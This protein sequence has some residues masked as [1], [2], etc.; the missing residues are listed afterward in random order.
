[1]TAKQKATSLI[2]DYYLP[3]LPSAQHKAGLTGLLLLIES[4]RRREIAPR[5]EIV[6]GPSETRV[7]IRLSPESLKALFDEFFAAVTIIH[8]DKQGKEKSKVFPR[9]EFLE[10]LGMPTCWLTLWRDVIANVIRAGAPAQFKSYRDRIEGAEPPNTWDWQKT[11]KELQ[12]NGSTAL[13]ASDFLGA[14]GTNA[15]RIPFKNQSC[16]AFLLIFA[17]LVSLTYI[18]QTLKRT[19]KKGEA[20]GSYRFQRNAY[21][22]VTP[23]VAVL[24]DFIN[25]YPEMLAGLNPKTWGNDPYP[26]EARISVPEEGGLEFLSSRRI[27]GERTSDYLVADLVASVQ[28]THLKYGKGSPHLLHVGTV[29]AEPEMLRQYEPIHQHCQNLFFRELRI[30]NL[31]GGHPWFEGADALLSEHPAEF[32]IQIRDKTPAF[33]FFGADVRR[34]FRGILSDLQE[35]KG[36][37]P[38]P[39][40][41]QDQELASQIYRLLGQFVN[42]RTKEKTDMSW[43][44][45]KNKRGNIQ[46]YREAREKVCLDAFLAMRGR[47]G[48]DLVSYF[49]GTLCSVPQ[50]LNHDRF[51]T[52][53]QHLLTDPEKIKTLAMLALSAHSYLWD[54][55]ENTQNT[56][57]AK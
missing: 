13:S 11:W 38:M 49:T 42:E 41:W 21:V 17:P 25:D 16:D 10:V 35:S 19:A 44:D 3:D 7:S 46:Q 34:T 14:E 28:I 1:M 39:D 23:E 26:A 30:K 8:K 5:P 22:V 43:E 6:K 47:N 36:A 54:R 50:N 32:F 48:H 37:N 55:S 52:V 9:A 18:S 56:G 4:M 40:D 27:V 53:S 31:L 20:N 24:D 29:S 33:S 51:L 45:F 15:E 2:L 12:A 57:E